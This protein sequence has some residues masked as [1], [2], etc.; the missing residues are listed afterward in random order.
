LGKGKGKEREVVQPRR[1]SL[2]GAYNYFFAVVAVLH[3]V[4]RVRDSGVLTEVR[5]LQA[6]R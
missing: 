2:L 1:A 5:V 4:G 3:M 6:A